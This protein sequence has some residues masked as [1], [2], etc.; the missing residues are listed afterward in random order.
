[1]KMVILFELRYVA[2]LIL[3]VVRVGV[4]SIETSK[5]KNLGALGVFQ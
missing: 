1:M 2:K 4:I 5:N 3:Q